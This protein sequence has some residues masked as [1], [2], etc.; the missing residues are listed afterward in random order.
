MPHSILANAWHGI[1]CMGKSCSNSALSSGLD[2]SGSTWEISD[3]WIQQYH[4]LPTDRFEMVSKRSFEEAQHD[5]RQ[6]TNRPSTYI[7]I[8]SYAYIYIPRPSK[9]LRFGTPIQCSLRGYVSTPL[10]RTKKTQQDMVI[11]N[12]VHSTIFGRH[13]WRRAEQQKL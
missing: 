7:Y 12:D 11:Y 8:Y 4:W 6:K 9:G 13:G 5:L 1:N 3:I 10:S 2:V